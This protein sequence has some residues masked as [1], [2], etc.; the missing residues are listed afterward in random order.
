MDKHYSHSDYIVQIKNLKVFFGPD[1]SIAALK[2]IDLNIPQG[3]ITAL[4]G[5]SGSGKSL[6]SLAIMGLLPHEAKVQGE[7]FFQGNNLCALSEKE[8]RKIRGKDIAM[9][10][11][12]PMSALNPLIS[13]GKQIAESIQLHQSCTKEEAKDQAIYWMQQV[14]IPDPETTYDKYPHQLSGGQKQRIMIAMAMANKPKLLIADEPSTALDV[15]VQKEIVALLLQLQKQHGMSVLFITHDMALAKGIADSTFEIKNG[16]IVDST[17]KINEDKF[18]QSPISNIPVLSIHQLSVVYKQKGIFKTAVDKVSFQLFQGE[19]VG[20]VGG[21]G[22]GKTTLSKAILGLVKTE[23]GEIFFKEQSIL[24]LSPN[25]WKALRKEIQI[26]YQDPYASLNPRIKVG[27]A[28]A[29][30]M[31]V[32]LGYSH[33]QAQQKAKEWLER[34]QLSSNDYDKYPHEFSGGQRQRICIARALAPQP[35]LVICDESVAALDPNI[36]QQILKLL[37]SLQEDLALTY[38]FITHDLDV[39]Q[40]FCNRVLVMQEGQIIEEGATDDIIHCPKQPY[41]QDLIAAMPIHYSFKP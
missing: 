20:L 39:V 21:S 28:I 40:R 31:R 34:V 14:L 22:C 3:A 26:I 17:E 8:L 4:I 11:Q 30:P 1:R 12:E 13:C 29:E 19:R 36:Q 33:T 15:L 5:S 6:T 24:P 2:G 37:V 35:S 27:E 38:L 41:T 23:S 32:H 9:I 18:C 10:F 7:I 16:V 25:A